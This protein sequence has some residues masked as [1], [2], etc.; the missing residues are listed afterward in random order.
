M[1]REFLSNDLTRHQDMRGTKHE[2]TV[3]DSPQQNGV[4]EHGMH[5]CAE[6]VR[7]LLLAS[8]LL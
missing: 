8:G 5:T 7:A 6:R 3:H 4:A 2:L 1:L